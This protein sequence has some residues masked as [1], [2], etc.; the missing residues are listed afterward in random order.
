MRTDI[1]IH[2]TYIFIYTDIYTYMH[3]CIHTKYVSMH[4]YIHKYI[5]MFI[6]TDIYIYTIMHTH[7]DIDKYLHIQGRH[8]AVFK[9]THI[10]MCAHR[11][12]HTHRGA[13]THILVVVFL[14]IVFRLCDKYMLKYFC[15]FVL[16]NTFPPIDFLIYL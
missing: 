4:K 8:I 11:E 3:T 10:Y 12:K 7:T 15:L 5:H 6:H 14:D 16:T 13:H 1:N 2:S 9:Q